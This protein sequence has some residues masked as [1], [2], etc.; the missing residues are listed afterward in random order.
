M[1]SFVRRL[2]RAGF[3]LG[4]L[5]DPEEVGDIFTRNVGLSPKYMVL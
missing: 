5:F 4:L 2:L 3:L 1:Q